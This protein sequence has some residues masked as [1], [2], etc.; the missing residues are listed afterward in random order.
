M[1]LSLAAPSPARC[2]IHDS[3]DQRSFAPVAPS[4]FLLRCISCGHVE[5]QALPS[6]TTAGRPQACEFEQFHTRCPSGATSAI[7]P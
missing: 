2:R 4:L 3:V 7:P 1:D 5:I 6:A